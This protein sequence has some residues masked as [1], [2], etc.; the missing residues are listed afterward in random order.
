[1]MRYKTVT[2]SAVLLFLAALSSAN[3]ASCNFSKP[4]GSCKGTISI[5]STKG[6]KGNYSAEATVRSSSPTC[7]KV[8]YLI[9]NTPNQTILK[10]GNS[11]SESLFG[12]SPVTKKTVK[13]T[14]CTAYEDRDSGASKNGGDTAAVPAG[15]K[16]FN[17][18]WEG[19]VGMMFLKA[20]MTLT[21]NVSGS[22]VTGGS[23]AHNGTGDYQIR[24]GRVSGNRVTFDYAQPMG[25][26]TASVVITQKS[27]N[28]IEY[29]GSG[30]GIT[31]SGTLIRK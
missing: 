17:G 30:Q 26:E 15:P 29:V 19:Q 25:G 5:D 23:H 11:D 21:M 9:D 12:T 1:M 14:K 8:E 27:A 2:S 6:S 13:V 3:A 4:I 24:N 28:S 31:M 7:S 22:S 18:T 20:G 16:F 10:S